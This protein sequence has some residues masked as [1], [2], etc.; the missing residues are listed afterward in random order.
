MIITYTIDCDPDEDCTCSAMDQELLH[1][2]ASRVI[3]LPR[4]LATEV[5]AGLLTLATQV[6][7]GNGFRVVTD[8]EFTTLEDEGD[9]GA[10]YLEGYSEEALKVIASMVGR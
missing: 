8:D 4:A 5:V 1:D 7:S 3:D 6:G 9:T 2:Y 10:W